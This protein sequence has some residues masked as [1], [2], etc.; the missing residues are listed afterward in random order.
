MTPNERHRA[1]P[2]PVTIRSFQRSDQSECVKIFSDGFDKVLTVIIFTALTITSRY[3]VIAIVFASIGAMLWSTWILAVG[4]AVVV[5]LLAYP[6]IKLYQVGA[7]T[8]KKQILETDF[9]DLE[10][11]YMSKE[12]C[13]MWVAEWNGKVVGMV[14][15]MN[16]EPGVAEIQRMHVVPSCRGMGIGKKLLN[17][18][19]AYAKKQGIE[20]IELTTSS[21]QVAA[22][23]LYKKHGFKLVKEIKII[24]LHAALGLSCRVGGGSKYE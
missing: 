17:E 7:L 10:K 9:K 12:G 8:W 18:L 4:A 13:H 23:G 16:H 19:V 15:L 22:I 1:T 14:G 21:V 5:S 2:L 3:S 6:F 20:K 24:L 11:S